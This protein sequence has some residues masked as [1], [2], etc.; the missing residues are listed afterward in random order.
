MD[1]TEFEA[2][3]YDEYDFYNIN[4]RTAGRGSGKLRT[5]REAEEHTNRHSPGGHERK[6]TQKLQ[7]LEAKRK[8][9]GKGVLCA[10]RPERHQDHGDGHTCVRIK[11]SGT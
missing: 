3:Y 10:S 4:D 6:I 9:E 1:I 8:D 7:N 2:E 11:V 5:K